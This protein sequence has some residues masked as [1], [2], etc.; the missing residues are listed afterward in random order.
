[1]T[2]ALHIN[3]LH[4]RLLSASPNNNRNEKQASLSGETKKKH[5]LI[6]SYSYDIVQIQKLKNQESIEL[7]PGEATTNQIIWSYIIPPLSFCEKKTIQVITGKELS[8]S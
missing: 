6:P 7:D 4:A 2:R 5:F 3:T 8:F 1:M